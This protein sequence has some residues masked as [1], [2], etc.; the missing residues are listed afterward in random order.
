MI[1]AEKKE[2]AK[3]KYTA[4]KKNAG[5]ELKDMFEN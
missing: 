5:D 3:K 4:K 1:L 2:R